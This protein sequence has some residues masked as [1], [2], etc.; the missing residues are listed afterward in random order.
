MSAYRQGEKKLNEQEQMEFFYEMFDAS[1]PR[2]GPGDDTST[3]KALDAVLGSLPEGGDPP[4]VLDLGCGNG[5]Q[6]LT[7]AIAGLQV[8]AL[9]NH[10]P[11][12]DELERRAAA[13]GV[14]D[15][16]VTRLADMRD[17]GLEAESFDLVWSEGALYVMGFREGL[18]YCYSLLVPGGFLAATE[19]CWLRPGAPAE[20]RSFLETEYPA[21]ADVETNLGYF[22]ECGFELTGRFTLPES[23]WLEQYYLPLE[24]RLRVLRGEHAADADRLELIERVQL[25]IETYR[26]Y[27]AYYGYEFFIARR[28]VI[29]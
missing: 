3:R 27:S 8:L 4:R 14:S 18:A 6:T 7:L 20:C 22:D 15:R 26:K 24:A 2:L 12:L 1:L 11:F 9:D 19:L 5:A 28:P 16:V 10:R 23:T 13:A 21:V 25:E 17:A 29:E